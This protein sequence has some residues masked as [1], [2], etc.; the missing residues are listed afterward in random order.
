MP[1]A[2]EQW[3]YRDALRVWHTENG[4]GPDDGDREWEA[5]FEELYAQAADH[6][7]GMNL[8][9]SDYL[10]RANSAI[11]RCVISVV[12][13]FVPFTLHR[14]TSPPPAQRIEMVNQSKLRSEEEKIVPSSNKPASAPPPK[15]MPPPLRDLKEGQI[16]N[17]K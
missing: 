2:L 1:F 11:V 3:R 12:I 6:N 17:K 16:P 4:N 8:A 5:Y 10:F 7:A 15:P 13:A 9:R 14:V